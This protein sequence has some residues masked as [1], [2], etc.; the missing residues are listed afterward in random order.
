MALGCDGAYFHRGDGDGSAAYDAAIANA[1]RAYWTYQWTMMP[2]VRMSHLTVTSMGQ[3]QADDAGVYDAKR[4]PP[5]TVM[6]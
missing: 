2:M 5:P 3:R 4:A 6:A 1:D